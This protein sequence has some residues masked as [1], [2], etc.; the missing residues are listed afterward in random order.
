MPETKALVKDY[1]GNLIPK[2]NARKI[3]GKYYEDGVSCFKMED[4]QWYRITS[5]DK[6]IFDHYNK[7]YI[8]IGSSKLLTGIVNEGGGEG[9]FSDN[10]FYIKA[11]AN[12]MDGKRG[13]Y[14]NILNEEVAKSLGFIE[15]LFDGVFYKSSEITEEDKKS[16]FNKRNIPNNERSKSYNLEADPERK[17]ELIKNYENYTPKISSSA[18]RMAKFLGD[19]SIGMEAEVINGFLP[20]RIRSRL[21]LKALKDGSLR[22]EAGEGIEIVSM[23]MKGAKAIET[24]REFCEELT[25]RCEVNNLCSV[26]FHF[27]NVRKDKLYILSVYKVIRLVQDELRS[28]FPF[29]RFNSI[30]PDGKIYCN[31]LL[32]LQIDYSCILRSKSEEEFKEN[33]FQEFNKIYKWLNNGKGLAVSASEPVIVR[34]EVIVNG[35]KMFYDQW[36]NEVYTTKSVNHAITGEKWNKPQRYYIFNFLNLFFNKIG[37]IESRCHEG[38]TNITKSLVWLFVSASI[39]RYAENI[40]EVFEAKTITLKE[41]LEDNLPKAYVNYIMAYMK[42]RHE[43]FFRNDGEYRAYNNVEKVWFADDIKFKFEYENM[44]IK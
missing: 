40:K 19:F 34:K 2:N 3:M 17:K 23:P 31:L 27:G 29:S 39:L 26:H 18:K 36:F 43:T 5:T 11:A 21:G 38:S 20:R 1:K 24:I 22:S 32:D 16:W 33:V 13:N 44:E 12:R 35:K 8:L 15:S 10:D 4:D 6:I 9:S 14:T 25:Q 42:V 30:K 37:T 28:Y 41:V 7:K